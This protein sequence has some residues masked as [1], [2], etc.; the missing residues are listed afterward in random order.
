MFFITREKFSGWIFKN[1]MIIVIFLQASLYSFAMGENVFE[2][3]ESVVLPCQYSGI[4]PERNPA[5]IWRRY[6]LKPQTI[7]LRRE[8]E[9]DLRGQHQRFSGRTSMKSDALD[10]LDFSLTLRKPHL[11]DSG[12]YTC[13]ISD[14]REEVRV[15]DVQLQVKVKQVEVTVQE[16][17][18]S[19]VLPCK[20]AAYMEEDDTVE[21]TRSEPEFMIAY[22]YQNGSNKAKE[23]DKSY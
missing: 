9:D 2:G 15:T 13:I 1:I 3:A 22:V 5:V 8:D 23:Q 20:T 11:S 21:W 4:L 19:A 18:E 17:V 6:D 10:S 7:H 12:T 14:D 16:G